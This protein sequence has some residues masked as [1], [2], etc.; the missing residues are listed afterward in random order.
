MDVD[1][2]IEP[3]TGLKYRPYDQTAHLGKPP[4]GGRMADE[5]VAG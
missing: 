3:Y 2:Y 4:W 5:A 1:R